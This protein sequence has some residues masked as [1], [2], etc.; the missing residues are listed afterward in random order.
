M[1]NDNSTNIN[2]ADSAS[3]NDPSSNPTQS[4]PPQATNPAPTPAPAPQPEALAS[5]S[6][7]DTPSDDEI[8]NDLSDNET[9]D[10]FIAAIMNE[11]GDITDN[12]QVN[13]DVHTVLKHQLLEQ[14][15]RSLVAELPDDKLDQLSKMAE[16]NGKIDPAV[17]ANMIKEANLDVTDI[18]GVTMARFRDI[19]L[20]KDSAG[21]TEE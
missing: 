18:V 3:V 11:K 5:A 19:Y 6:S 17:I 7:T 10:L 13:Q 20:G 4:N 15:D 9:I 14:I 1:D 21:K 8:L 16:Q 2:L 12:D